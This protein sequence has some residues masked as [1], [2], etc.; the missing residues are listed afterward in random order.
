V[1]NGIRERRNNSIAGYTH[2]AINP[3]STIQ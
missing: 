2:G 3:G 1:V